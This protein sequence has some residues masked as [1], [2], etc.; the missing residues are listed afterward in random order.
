MRTTSNFLWGTESWVHTHT[1]F[2]THRMGHTALVRLG[3]QGMVTIVHCRLAGSA[4]RL[5]QHV[6]TSRQAGRPKG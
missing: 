1:E 2:K 5:V 4:G 6:M 3:R